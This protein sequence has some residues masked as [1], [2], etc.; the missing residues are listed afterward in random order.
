MDFPNI[1]YQG[2]K[3]FHTRTQTQ[4]ERAAAIRLTRFIASKSK[5]SVEKALNDDF[6]LIMLD[7]WG[8]AAKCTDVHI[9]ALLHRIAD[10]PNFGHLIIAQISCS[11]VTEM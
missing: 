8:E 2:H 10:L 7:R 6:I 4:F 9:I 5:Q 1:L 11:L 3:H